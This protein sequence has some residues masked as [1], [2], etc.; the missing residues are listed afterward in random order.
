MSVGLCYLSFPRAESS[1]GGGVEILGCTNVFIL[2]NMKKFPGVLSRG[3]TLVELIVVVAIIATML[4]LAGSVLRDSSK[5]QGLQDAV[6][7]LYAA[8]KE[9]RLEAQS[10]A[11]WARLVVVSDPADSGRNTRN[12]RYIAVMVK[13][14]VKIGRRVDPDSGEWRV[15]PGGRYLPAGFFVSPKYSTI[16]DSPTY[17]DDVGQRTSSTFAQLLDKMKMGNQNEPMRD[18]Y[19]V[20]FDPQGRMAE[21]SKPTR[22]VVMSGT[23]D[24]SVIGDDAGV[25][26]SPVDS[27]GLPTLIGGIVIWPKGNVSLIKT[28]EQI[29]N[30][31]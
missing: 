19:F 24:P 11:T 22:I 6:E 12:L 28:R 25:R 13:E 21:P 3:F 10:K 26:P 15:I 2:L 7:A 27:D 8:A 20:E 29:F 17:A 1:C 9:A 4:A 23:T 31:H 18:V 16:V 14:P 5:G 30:G